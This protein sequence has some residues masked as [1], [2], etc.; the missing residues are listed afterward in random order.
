M[1]NLDRKN[2]NKVTKEKKIEIDVSKTNFHSLSRLLRELQTR[3]NF[4]KVEPVFKKL[5]LPL[6][7]RVKPA[8]I[9]AI[10]PNTSFYIDA[11]GQKRLP[12]REGAWSLDKLVRLILPS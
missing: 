3:E 7:R 9:M 10:V 2:V 12:I 5:N 1:E 6:T 8:D 11:D 4:K